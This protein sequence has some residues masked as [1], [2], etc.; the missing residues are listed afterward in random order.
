MEIQTIVS[1]TNFALLSFLSDRREPLSRINP[2]N[3]EW[4]C[5][6]QQLHFNITFFQLSAK[7]NITFFRT[8][9]SYDQVR[10]IPTRYFHIIF[11]SNKVVSSNFSYRNYLPSTQKFK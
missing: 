8:I 5:L 3:E 7:R 10:V 6:S 4:F 11:H 1:G 9:T 2:E